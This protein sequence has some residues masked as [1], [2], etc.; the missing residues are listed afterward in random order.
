[1]TLSS[2]DRT[3][4]HRDSGGGGPHSGSEGVSDV[5]RAEEDF[6]TL[7]T[8]A[9]KSLGGADAPTPSD[10]QDCFAV[11]AATSPAIAVEELSF[12]GRS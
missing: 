2:K 5:R 6:A 4:L 1:M 7:A 10:L 8:T 3:F 11:F 9:Q 12:I